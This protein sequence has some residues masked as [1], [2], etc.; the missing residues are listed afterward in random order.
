MKM[1]TKHIELCKILWGRSSGGNLGGYFYL[2]KGTPQINDRC[3][4]LKKPMTEEI[5]CRVSRRKEIIIRRTEINTSRVIERSNK[6]K[7]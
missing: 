7:S 6:I 4:V 5:K 1:D 2:K 3:Y